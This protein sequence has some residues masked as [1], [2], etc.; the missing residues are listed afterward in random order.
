MSVT[1]LAEVQDQIQTFWSPVFMQ[2]LR[3]SFLLPGLVSKEYE[4]EM[5]KKGDTVTVSQV[6]S[7]T[8]ELRDVGTNADVFEPNQ[9]STSK[10][11]IKA[12]KRAV[13]AVEF[14]DLVEIQSLV[15]PIKGKEVRQAMMHD[16]GR[17]INDTYIP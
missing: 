10:V 13:S 7:L 16:I 11:D 4:G 2:E 3:E 17:Q 15:D 12:D 5:K 14:D 1:T 6:N 8:S 9:I